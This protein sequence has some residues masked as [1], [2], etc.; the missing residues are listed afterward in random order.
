[1]I[2][3][4]ARVIGIAAALIAAFYAGWSVNGWRLGQQMERWGKELAQAK[5][6]AY[7]E[8]R[9]AEFISS[10]L[11][12][13]NAELHAVKVAAESQKQKVIVKEVIKYAKADYAGKCDLPIKWVR[14]DTAS[15]AGVSEDSAA[16]AGADGAASGITDTDAIAV[17]QDRNFICRTEMMKLESLQNYVRE[18]L[19]IFGRTDGKGAGE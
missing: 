1:M 3:M 7:Q 19:E 8:A 13:R 9:K 18:Q 12:Q 15:A 11:A 17:I 6:Q 4:Q 10:E 14:I 5:V 2:P 16:I